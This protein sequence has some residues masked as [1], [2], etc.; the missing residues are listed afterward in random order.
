MWL[1]VV[2]KQQK[3]RYYLSEL[4]EHNAKRCLNVG[5]IETELFDGWKNQT[6]LPHPDKRIYSIYS[7]SEMYVVG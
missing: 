7:W 1:D 6:H 2:K 3:T 4:A 5:A